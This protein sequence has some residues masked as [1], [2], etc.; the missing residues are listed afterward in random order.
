MP[1]R[2]S[3]FPSFL[4]TIKVKSYFI[5]TIF[6]IVSA[7]ISGVIWNQMDSVVFIENLRLQNLIPQHGILYPIMIRVIREFTSDIFSIIITIKVV[8]NLFFLFSI[9]YLLLIFRVRVWFTIF[10]M[11]ILFP[12]FLIQ[13]GVFSE[14]IFCS[15]SILFLASFFS[16]FERESK[17]VFDRTILLFSLFGLIATRHVGL[18]F[19]IFP[20]FY[21]FRECWS[22][23]GFSWR[24]YLPL[25]LIVFIQLGLK[26]FILIKGQ[27][28]N[29]S[30]VGRPGLSVIAKVFIM[31]PNR[32]NNIFLKWQ[33]QAS[34]NDEQKAQ[35][36]IIDNLNG[37]WLEPRKAI[38][39]YLIKQ[40]PNQD[41][42]FLEVKTEK[43]MNKA[44]VNFLLIMDKSV[45][46]YLLG[47]F[48]DF[49]KATPNASNDILD[50]HCDPSFQ[51]FLKSKYPVLYHRSFNQNS[52]SFLIVRSLCFLSM[53]FI[54]F[55]FVFVFLQLLK[56]KTNFF[57]FTL[58]LFFFFQI[59]VH[60]STTVVLS[61]YTLLGLCLLIFAFLS[62]Y[63]QKKPFSLF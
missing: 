21:F 19:L 42:Y 59:I 57:F 36:I 53:V 52:F 63:D 47:A 6:T 32:K 51:S 5:V 61:R 3:E 23:L 31:N 15:F 4:I 11:I 40:Y 29:V 55:L 7:I 26:Q 54:A 60:I 13:N 10:L 44:Y 45:L 20:L 46:S 17:S 27:C 37:I 43:L 58:V 48:Y 39:S 41:D 16:L 8:Q 9:Y 50:L 24:K 34:S 38:K 33:R 35:Q 25:I 62:T 18:L 30:M 14:A 56:I 2:K 22:G 49:L 28:L 1:F 12:M